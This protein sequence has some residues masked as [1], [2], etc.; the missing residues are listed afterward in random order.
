MFRR[1]FTASV[2]LSTVLPFAQSAE[3]GYWDFDGAE[4]GKIVFLRYD[5]RGE[6][7]ASC[8]IDGE[9]GSWTVRKSVWGG[10][11]RHSDEYADRAEALDHAVDWMQET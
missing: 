9:V 5:G 7:C 8:I 2:V 10:Q 4:D 1:E 3:E 6:K 11:I